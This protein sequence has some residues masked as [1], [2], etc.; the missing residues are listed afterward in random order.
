VACAHPNTTVLVSLDLTRTRGRPDEASARFDVDPPGGA[1][2]LPVL[3][4]I[5]AEHVSSARVLLDHHAVA[6]PDD[7]EPHV[8]DLSKPAVVEKGRRSLSARLEGKPG[9]RLAVRVLADPGRADVCR[10]DGDD[11]H[12]RGD[13]RGDGD[14]GRNGAGGTCGGGKGGPGGSGP[15][16][17][18]ATPPDARAAGSGGCGN[19]GA[20]ASLSALALVL[21][22]RRFQT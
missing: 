20:A 1:A 7:F 15:D 16:A 9:S 4:C 13:D 10:D 12:D 8:V 11:D 18:A 19:A 5:H 6:R 14:S 21:A 3:V 22:R 17:P 2:T